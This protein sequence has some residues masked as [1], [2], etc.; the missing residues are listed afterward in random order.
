M[1][2][3]LLAGDLFLNAATISAGLHRPRLAEAS[4]DLLIAKIE[5][6]GFKRLMALLQ[7]VNSKK[8]WSDR[9]PNWDRDP[10]AHFN[11]VRPQGPKSSALSGVLPGAH[12]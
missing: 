10:G 9:F 3:F 7:E 2:E 4:A 11:R 6:E 5:G 8:V 1:D 12:R